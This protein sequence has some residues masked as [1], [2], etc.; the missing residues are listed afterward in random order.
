MA[1]HLLDSP[2]APSYQ[3]SGGGGNQRITVDP[4]PEAFGAGIGRAVQGFGHVTSEA[5]AQAFK[6]ADFY[7]QVAGDDAYNNLQ[8]FGTKLIH[9]DPK[10]TAVGADGNPIMGPD[11]KPM[12]DTGF[13]GTRGADTLRRWQDVQKRFDDK[14]A[15]IRGGLMS[16]QQRHA[17]DANSRR[18]RS[19]MQNQIGAHADQQ[20]KVYGQTT[21]EAAA[22]IAITAIGLNADDPALVEQ[23][24]EQL[25]HV[26]TK[27]VQLA[28][29]DK[30]AMDDAIARANRDALTAR[31]QMIGVNDPARAQK[32]LDDNKDVAGPAYVQMSEHLRHRKDQAVA[33][34]AAT[35]ALTEERAAV[36]AKGAPPLPVFAQ[37]SQS[38]PG[39]MSPQGMMRLT[40]IEFGGGKNDPNNP[41]HQGPVQASPAYWDRFG[42][43]GDRNNWQDSLAALARSTA[44]DRKTL[45]NVLGR[46]PTDAEL[47]LAHQQGP[48]GASALL[49]NPTMN[50]VDALSQAYG[51]DK[52]KARAAIVANGGDPAGTAADFAGKWIGKFGG[53][54][55]VPSFAPGGGAA[56]VLPASV[57]G[58][59]PGEQPQQQGAPQ[60][61]LDTG[62][63]AHA[64]L[65][66]AAYARIMA[67]TS[68]TPEQR[69]MAL[70]R[71]DMKIRNDAEMHRQDRA[72][73]NSLISD[74]LS[75]LMETGKGID[76]LTSERVSETFGTQTQIEFQN[77]RTRA[78]QFYDETHNYNLLPENEIYASINRIKPSPG[79]RGYDAQKKYYDKAVQKA[80]DVF[81]DR[82]KDPAGS[83]SS[84]SIVRSALQQTDFSDPSSVARLVGIRMAAQESAGIPEGQRQP[85]TRSEAIRIMSPIVNALPGTE[86]HLLQQI[87]PV[88]TKTY[89]RYADRAL[90]FALE[91]AKVDADSARVATSIFKKIGLG[92]PVTPTDTQQLQTAQTN[93]AMAAAGVVAGQAVAEA[94]QQQPKTQQADKT[95]P[96]NVRP[97]SEAIRALIQNP[98]RA[99]EF[100]ALFGKGM[101]KR[102]LNEHQT[103]TKGAMPNG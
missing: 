32:M 29:G 99:D 25:R 35:K 28:G 85:M 81:S 46:D 70:H 38:V 102:V 34:G 59:G 56:H 64:N 73:M 52:A 14:I 22:R 15:E 13:M 8:D 11:G 39:A 84:A 3:P 24:T 54:G 66:A 86:R 93:D 4:T 72:I 1:I 100:D 63:I 98:T 42:G 88:I 90:Q 61:V 75:S 33:E 57:S 7:A 77:E 2:A 17:F 5:G 94:A 18:L 65:Q 6:V 36:T 41:K 87:V 103:M 80:N 26:Y 95:Q 44:A 60:P 12:P 16:D 53:G 92:H 69:Q 21:N 10:A 89:G 78:K 91:Q 58:F 79:M 55:G 9:G 19:A 47:Y 74:D 68:L 62:E 48:G 96:T 31:V 37:A 23:N 71:V 97:P 83:V 27:Q 45:T 82:I 67:D 50:A 101:A 40:Q 43:G 51:G 49:R 30:A 20:M 76:G